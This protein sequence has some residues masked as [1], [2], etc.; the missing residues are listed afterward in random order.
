M[1][2]CANIIPTE[3][4]EAW[5]DITGGKILSKL[6]KKQLIVTQKEAITMGKGYWKHAQRK[7]LELNGAIS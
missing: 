2:S 6:T 1:I 5:S 4:G 7:K 3:Q